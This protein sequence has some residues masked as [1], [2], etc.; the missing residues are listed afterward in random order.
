MLL[1]ATALRQRLQI[2]AAAVSTLADD[3]A[4]RD[5]PVS[6][7]DFEQAIRLAVFAFARIASS[8][9]FACSSLLQ[10]TMASSA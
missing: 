8:T 5:D 1:Y 2:H 7:K 3:W 6:F 9:C 10:W 4:T